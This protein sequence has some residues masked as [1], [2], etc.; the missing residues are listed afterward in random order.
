[1]GKYVIAQI[2]NEAFYPEYIKYASKG[3][4]PLK[5]VILGGVILYR[6]L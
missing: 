3:E 1:M 5:R 4:L 6:F 2:M